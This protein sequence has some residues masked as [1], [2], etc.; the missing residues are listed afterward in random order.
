MKHAGKQLFILSLDAIDPHLKKM[1]NPTDAIRDIWKKCFDLS[2]EPQLAVPLGGGSIN[3]V[4]KI[5][6]PEESVVLKVHRIAEHPGMFAAESKGLNILLNAHGPLVPGVI[7]ETVIGNYQ[8]LVLE[9]VSAGTKKENYFARLGEDMA[10]LHRNTAALYGL[11]HDNYIGS[12]PQKNALTANMFD[13]LI[14]H[15][16]EPMLKAA[17]DRQQLDS[18]DVRGFSGFFL[19]LPELLPVEPPTLIHGDLWSGN[20]ITGHEGYACL[21]DPAVAYVHRE[22]D[23]SKT[24]LFGGFEDQFYRSYHQLFPLERGFQQRVAFW[25]LYPLLVHIVLFGGGYADKV[26]KIVHPFAV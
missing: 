14:H 9:Y 16:Y 6:L 4:Y 3:A 10:A 20:V 2:L 11:D 22:A 5:V 8:F 23:I 15:R 18:K 12:L 19:R 25:N 26:R 1:I 17:V 13:F 24:L 7:C 21:I